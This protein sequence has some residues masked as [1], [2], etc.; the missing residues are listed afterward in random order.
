MVEISIDMT[1]IH[2]GRIWAGGVCPDCAQR[3]RAENERAQLLKLLRRTLEYLPV[4]LREEIEKV[5]K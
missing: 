4:Q 2:C 1:C 3:I 5:V